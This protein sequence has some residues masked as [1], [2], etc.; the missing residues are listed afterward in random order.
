MRRY[1]NENGYDVNADQFVAH[2]TMKGW[3]VGRDTMKDWQAAVRT[4]HYKDHP[5]PKQATQEKPKNLHQ[6][7]VWTKVD[8]T[9]MNGAWDYGY[10]KNGI[11]VIVPPEA[12]PRP[13]D[14]C[15]WDGSKW[16]DGQQEDY[17]DLS[18]YFKK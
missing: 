12:M 14:H 7:L 17:G 4:W 10:F 18:R 15:D 11:T 13:N 3:K 16:V 6:Y 5:T 9:T 1:C 2:Y 8:P